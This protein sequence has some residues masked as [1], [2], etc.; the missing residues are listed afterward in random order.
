M[1]ARMRWQGT[2]PR[3]RRPTMRPIAELLEERLA[4]AIFNVLPTLTDGSV[5]S[6]RYAIDQ[7][8]G[9]HDAS[10]TINLAAGHYQLTDTTDG[11]LLIQD[12]AGIPSKTLKITGLGETTSFIEPASSSW[13]TRIFQIIGK[14]GAS[15]SVVFS[16]LQ[17]DDGKAHDGGAVGGTAALGGGLLIQGAN[18]TLK[19]VLVNGNSARGKPGAHGLPGVG[20]VPGGPGGPG[21][22]AKG[23]GIYLAGGKLTLIDSVLNANSADGGS[24]GA[25]GGGG[26]GNSSAGQTGSVGS[27]GA[28]GKA[29]IN[30]EN[31]GNGGPGGNGTKGG[32]AGKGTKSPMKFGAGGAGAPE[33]TAAAAGSSSRAVPS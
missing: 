33:A 12:D 11:N 22:N 2:I 10:N 1:N 30:G 29:G 28:A 4:P 23:G 32:N 15:V 18:V 13:Q 24:G 8:N 19:D 25:G 3:R 31:G 7:A 17:V 27:A 5:G 16:N 6:L 20:S 26:P 9:N 21:G 14:T